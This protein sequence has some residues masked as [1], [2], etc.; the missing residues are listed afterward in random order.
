MAAENAASGSEAAGK[1][2]R[3]ARELSALG[4]RSE[5]PLPADD[6]FSDAAAQAVADR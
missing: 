2:G 5:R 1:P 3:Y 6:L 4:D